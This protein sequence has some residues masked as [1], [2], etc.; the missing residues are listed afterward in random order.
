[1]GS[2]WPGEVCLAGLAHR[3]PGR[4]NLDLSTSL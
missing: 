2:V 3:S 1:L 4:A